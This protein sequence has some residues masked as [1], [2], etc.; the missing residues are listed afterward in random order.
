MALTK[1]LLRMCHDFRAN[2]SVEFV[3]GEE[4]EFQAGDSQRRIFGVGFF[5]DLSGFVVADRGIQRRH[6]HQRVLEKVLHLIPIGFE[7]D[8][9]MIGEGAASV[10]Q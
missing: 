10:G 6:Q 8:D 3:A 7:P 4:A 2:I 9:Q 1:K 5:R